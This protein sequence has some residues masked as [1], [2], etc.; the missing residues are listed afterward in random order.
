MKTRNVLW[1]LVADV[2]GII[3]FVAIGRRNHDEGVAPTG[4]IETAA[5]FL[6]ALLIGWLIARA[7]NE[8]LT[9]RTGTIIWVT[10]VALGMVLRKFVFDDG[11]ATAFVIVA[12]VFTGA[13]L[14]G[15]RLA[16]RARVARV[17]EGS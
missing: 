5:P 3:V 14:N 16:I 15:W 12:T 1:A 6:I 10:T 11:T 13:V 8:P 17:R 7:W 9:T 4:V 2:I